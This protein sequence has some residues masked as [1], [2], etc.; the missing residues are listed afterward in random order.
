M[1]QTEKGI[2]FLTTNF[3]SFV[4]KSKTLKFIVPIVKLVGVEKCEYEQ[5]KNN[6]LNVML[7]DAEKLYTFIFSKTEIRD[8]VNDKIKEIWRKI[9][10]EKEKVNLN[11]DPK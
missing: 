6:S 8:T 11:F 1:E 10:S 4:A 2:L 9:L 3:I 5:G 7:E